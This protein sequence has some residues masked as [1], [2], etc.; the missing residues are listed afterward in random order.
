MRCHDRRQRVR[1]L[2]LRHVRLLLAL[3]EKQLIESGSRARLR[4]RRYSVGVSGGTEQYEIDKSL[5]LWWACL[6]SN[7]E[8]DRYERC[9]L[10]C[11][12]SAGILFKSD[13]SFRSRWTLTQIQGRLLGSQVRTFHNRSFR[14]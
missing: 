10:T 13:S 12:R 3:G 11:K 5:I 2:L 6:D 9:A 7:Q 4:E 14:E 1:S 8:P